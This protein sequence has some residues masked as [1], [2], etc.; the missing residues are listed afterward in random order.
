MAQY[1][2]YHYRCFLFLIQLGLNPFTFHDCLNRLP[3]FHHLYLLRFLYYCSSG[4]FSSFSYWGSTTFL[5]KSFVGFTLLLAK[6]GLVTLLSHVMHFY[7]SHP[8]ALLCC[9]LCWLC[10]ADGLAWTCYVVV[11]YA[12]LLHKSSISF[13]PL[14]A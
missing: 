13:P 2:L 6:C 11:L 5:Y 4:P 10:S 1:C 8:L 12:T 3:L 9:L 14:L 7:I